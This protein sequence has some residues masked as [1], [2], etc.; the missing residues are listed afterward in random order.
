MRAVAVSVAAGM[1]KKGTKAASLMP[2]S[3]SG[4]MKYGRFARMARITGLMPAL[5]EKIFTG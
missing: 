2:K 4:N 1:P 3:M 5:R